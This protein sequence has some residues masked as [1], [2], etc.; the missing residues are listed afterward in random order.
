MNR[1]KTNERNIQRSS[2]ADTVVRGVAQ[3]NAAAEIAAEIEAENVA[4]VHRH[5]NTAVAI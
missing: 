5:E 2:G 3:D 1:E 4:D